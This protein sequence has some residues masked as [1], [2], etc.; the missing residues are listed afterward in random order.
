MYCK[1]MFYIIFFFLTVFSTSV[2]SVGIGSYGSPRTLL[3]QPGEEY[4]FRYYLFDSPRVNVELQGDLT[5]YATIV[6]PDPQGPPRNIDVT[7]KMPDYLEPGQHQLYIVATESTGNKVAIGGIA[8]VREGIAVFALY[9]AKHPIFDSLDVSDV[10]VNEKTTLGVTVSNQGEEL[11]DD[12][13]GV[14][15]VYDQE[16]QTLAILKTE[17]KSIASND[18][19]SLKATLDAALYNMTPGKYRVQGSVT[20]D[21]AKM[22]DTVEGSLIVGELKVNIL[23]STKELIVNA[24]NKYYLTLESDWSGDITDVYAKIKTP[25]GKV[26]K[27][28]NIDLIKPSPGRKAAGIIEAYIETN[29][30]SLGEQ[31]LEVTLYYKGVS[32]TEQVKVNIIDGKPPV[33]DK[34]SVITPKIIFIGI[35][36]IIILFVAI[37]FL[38]FRRGGGKTG[39]DNSSNAGNTAYND[40]NI[41]PPSL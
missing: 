24:T 30:L 10:N 5:Q 26:I 18:K 13:S 19:Q 21:G 41:R 4:T 11:I 3:F 28:E 34:P 38:I 2:Y 39:S 12:A 25:N 22:E 16:N 33:L 6:D 32:T 23:D 15:T 14:I 40:A 31:D 27:T 7:I 1:K 9:P 36:V 17:S 35:S 8:S 29:D 20:Y 37:Y